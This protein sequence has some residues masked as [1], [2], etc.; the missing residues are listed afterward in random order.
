MKRLTLAITYVVALATPVVA[1]AASAPGSIEEADLRL[2]AVA[3]RIQ[4]ANAPL[5]DRT[6][7][8][9]GVALQSQDQ[10]PPDNDPGFE[11]TVAFAA[12][13]P[14]SPLA[15][16]GLAPGAGLVAIDGRAIARQAGLED[17]PLRD[18]A[19]AMLAEHPAGPLLLTVI[20]A[21][22]QRVV[23]LETASQC[24]ALV[25]VLVDDGRAARS[26]GRV[27]QIGL[28]LMRRASND[29]VAAI[30][31]HELAH[32][33]LRHRDR[34]SGA[35]VG[36][37]LAAQFGHDRRLNADAEIEADRLSVHLLA[38]AGYDPQV[39]T[40]LWRGTLGRQLDAGLF[41]SRI[42]ASPEERARTLQREIADYLAGGA[43]S[44]PGHLLARR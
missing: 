40:A 6:S 19:H 14:D 7:P 26:D 27:I 43:P 24:R 39:A 37:G 20:Q 34:L 11:S 22:E 21:G 29:E 5:C 36:K 16:A 15:Q 44:W 1:G 25:E 8:A 31:A 4:L 18:S 13:L 23:R 35:G 3:E 33:V 28:D 30:F 10:F 2:L 32:S 17:M 12:L 9:L 38:N 42:Y 41:R